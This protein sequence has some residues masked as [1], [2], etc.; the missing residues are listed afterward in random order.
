VLSQQVLSLS[1]R[2]RAAC[3]PLTTPPRLA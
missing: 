1:E 2:A 3:Y